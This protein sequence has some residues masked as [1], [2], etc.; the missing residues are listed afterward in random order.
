MSD[1]SSYFYSQ[2]G[3]FTSAVSGGVDPRTG[4]Y[5][6]NINLGHVA[7]N[8]LLGPSIPLVLSYSPMNQTNIGFGIGFSFG[9]ST[10][11]RGMAMLSL[12]D[13]SKYPISDSGSS[14]SIKQ[15][16]LQNLSFQIS[17]DESSYKIIH[18]DG[19]IELLDGPN[20]GG[21]IK[22]T[23]MIVSPHCHLVQIGWDFTQEQPR[24]SQIVD[25]NGTYLLMVEYQSQSQTVITVFPG[26]NTEITTEGY[27]ITLDFQDEYL[28]KIS[29]D[30]LNDDSL[31]W[32]L[33]YFTPE[34]S[35]GSWGRW[36][37]KMTAP[38][39]RVEDATYIYNDGHRFPEA[40][41]KMASTRV[42]YVTQYQVSTPG[43][44]ATTHSYDYYAHNS[45]SNY[46][47]YGCNVN[48]WSADEDILYY[49]DDSNF[50]Y[51][52]VETYNDSDGQTITVSRKYDSFHL[53]RETVSQ[54]EKAAVT[55]DMDYYAILGAGFDRQPPNF[56]FLKNKTVTWSTAVNDDGP[57]LPCTSKITTTA[58]DDYGNLLSSEQKM[59][60][61][62]SI[63]SLGTTEYEYYD[64]NGETYDENTG[65]GCP[66]DSNAFNVAN[67][68]P[69]FL[70]KTTT[71][72][73]ET[74]YTDLR[75]SIV[76]FGY[77]A[78]NGPTTKLL[79]GE[80]STAVFTNEKRT[81]SGEQLLAKSQYTYADNETN[82]TV[83]GKKMSEFG[84]FISTKNTHYPDSTTILDNFDTTSVLTT[85]ILGLDVAGSDIANT[86]V[87]TTTVTSHDNIVTKK[88]QISSRFTGRVLARIDEMGIRSSVTYDKLGRILSATT[89]EA[90]AFENTRKF[91]YTIATQ[92]SDDP[93]TVTATDALGNQGKAILDGAFKPLKGRVKLNGG[94]Q[95][96]TI[97]S[98]E[99]DILG[100]VS[101]TTNQDYNSLS[102]ENAYETATVHTQYDDWGKPF[103]VQSAESVSHY[104]INDPISLTQTAY[105][106]AGA[107]VDG[108]QGALQSAKLVKT[109][110]PSKAT[111]TIDTYENT[112]KTGDKPYSTL[113][114][115]YDGWRRLRSSTDALG[116]TTVFN[117]DAF[118]RVINT[119]LPDETVVTRIYSPDQAGT[120]STE[121][122]VN[123]NTLGIRTVDGLGRITSQT[124]EGNTDSAT[125]DS[126]CGS[127]TKPATL[128]TPYGTTI[129]YKYQPELGGKLISKT[130]KDGDAVNLIY[131]PLT[132]ALTNATST[133]RNTS[134]T[135]IIQSFDTAGHVQSETFSQGGDP[136]HYEYTTA[137]QLKTYTDVEGTK[138]AVK[139]FDAI[140]RP[141]CI[142]DNAV[143]LDLFYDTLGRLNKY[144]ATDIAANST[145]TTTVSWD[146][147]GREASRTVTSSTGNTWTIAYTHNK[148]DQVRTKTL[149]QDGQQTRQ[150]T[151]TYDN[152]NRLISASYDGSILP[153]DTKGNH[154]KYHEFE[155]DAINNLTTV[156]SIFSDGEDTCTYHYSPQ[157]PSRLVA[158]VHDH[159]SYPI[160]TL[161]DYDEAGRITDDGNG[162]KFVYEKGV[163]AGALQS[164]TKSDKSGGAGASAA[165]VYDP[166]GRIIKEDEVTLFYRGSTL[167]NQ[168]DGS[169]KTRFVH[170]PSGN[171]AQVQS[172]ENAGVW[173]SG[174]EATG[175]VLSVQNKDDQQT[176]V[177]GAHGEQGDD[178]QSAG[179]LGYNGERRS[180]A[181]GGYHLGNGYR[182][183]NPELRRF[184][185][186]DSMS[187]FDKGGINAYAYCE[188]DPV[189]NIDP[190]GHSIFAELK[191]AREGFLRA[192]RSLTNAPGIE[193]LNDA[194]RA[195]THR[196]DNAERRVHQE[197]ALAED[198]TVGDEI[199]NDLRLSYRFG[200]VLLQQV[201]DP[202]LAGPED[203]ALI[204]ERM[205]R[206][207]ARSAAMRRE[208]DRLANEDQRR[209]PN[210]FDA[211]QRGV[212]PRLVDADFNEHL[213]WQFRQC[214][215]RP[216]ERMGERPIWTPVRAPSGIRNV[217]NY[218]GREEILNQTERLI[219]FHQ[220]PNLNYN[221]IFDYIGRDK[222]SQ[223]S[224]RTKYNI[225]AYVIENREM[226]TSEIDRA[227]GVPRRT[228]RS[229]RE[230]YNI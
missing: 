62:G 30:A 218:N 64:A 29:S 226:S 161:I 131:A 83:D 87:S 228:I 5:S 138:G 178:T 44:E 13:G 107:A 136:T 112:A 97:R 194:L 55:T 225:I 129:S 170:G 26:K 229:I 198:R 57:V 27:K 179:S 165:F 160:V 149:E 147:L 145:L 82:V 200:D 1:A 155:Y 199:A 40:A 34:S 207:D 99:Y 173:L 15:N 174:T 21:H 53:L 84:Q 9:L 175:S 205:A 146:T 52:S 167:A 139:T 227:T 105:S 203:A 189:N 190:T 19:T 49:C 65:F 11:D 74:P 39:G 114:N 111:V 142:A 135:S 68:I 73:A 4:Q 153:T 79:S 193:Q 22:L 70:K 12:S 202:E 78:Y 91:E 104:T 130:T 41:T 2:A 28:M 69:N 140:G 125:Y 201:I 122:K 108:A 113:I 98:R 187:P 8:N 186:P 137:G 213:N 212:L 216:Q 181:L 96:Q 224:D 33:E 164:V 182:L 126:A 128:T 134:Q 152:R 85:N 185:A 183:Y 223:F 197:M 211:P 95:W 168:V 162:R 17:D 156:K 24:L 120:I 38:G 50:R 151:F 16:K 80:S 58:Y 67:N 6:V 37:H 177:Y 36:L 14:V 221:D 191:L 115:H 3:N 81:Y 60:Y 89:A 214:L 31:V 121:I 117:Y 166:L 150:E 32:T 110:N 45:T 23:Q 61:A 116:N 209:A 72:P 47:G 103:C 215:F 106:Q 171:I 56:Q 119:T 176:S 143:Q 100:R 222:I 46:L 184:A 51:S 204:T 75:P 7:A 219:N 172:G 48:S 144:V 102:D 206:T 25:E 127:L 148:N 123:G 118:G 66:P 230:R 10:Y 169:N 124:S 159:S 157:I 43:A 92:A 195:A 220:I 86:I 163:L 90:T 101:E 217:A 158:V 77:E 63:F 180:E 132:G 188:G 154:I 210:A 141:I 133:V 71:T 88:T 76:H 94:S 208:S 35:I 192:E 59:Q 93:F 20:R 42:P 54:R 109:V 18:K 196:L